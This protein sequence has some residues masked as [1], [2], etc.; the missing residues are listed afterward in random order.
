M[1]PWAQGSGPRFP[2]CT[3]DTQEPRMI[4]DVAIWQKH[5]ILYIPFVCSMK[6]A[7]SNFEKNKTNDQ[8]VFIAKDNGI[9]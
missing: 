9:H 4:C 3:F 5:K 2:A 6:T 1:L 8:A 7:W